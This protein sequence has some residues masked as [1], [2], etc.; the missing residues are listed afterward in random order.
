M[1]PKFE[2]FLVKTGGNANALA[3]LTACSL[4]L[5]LSSLPLSPV[6]AQNVSY[7][8]TVVA[9]SSVEHGEV[10]VPIYLD[11]SQTGFSTPHQFTGLRGIHKLSSV[12]EHGSGHF[13]QGPPILQ[14]NESSV[15]FTIMSE[16]VNWIE[17]GPPETSG[18]SAI[19]EFSYGST[20]FVENFRDAFQP[21]TVARLGVLVNMDP[22]RVADGHMEVYNQTVVLDSSN[23][24]PFYSTDFTIHGVQPAYVQFQIPQGAR[25]GSWAYRLSV[26]DTNLNF[27]EDSTFDVA[28]ISAP[29]ASYPPDQALP[30]ST[31]D[32]A[33]SEYMLFDNPN[34]S[35]VVL[36]VGGGMIGDISG[37]TPI[38]G[39]SEIGRLGTA[40]YR[41]VYDLVKSGFS[42]VTPYGP[43]Q[44]L[45]FPSSL[46]GH[47]R[48]Q[49]FNK[50]YALGHSAGGVV[51]AWAVL[52]NP[53]LF[54]KAVIADAPLTR[55]STGF[56]FTDLSVRSEQ[57][58]VP[59]LLIWG[60]GDTQADVGNAFAWMD[61]ADPSLAVLKIYDYYHDWAGTAAE[62]QVR[63]QIASFFKGQNR[64]A[65]SAST[66]NSGGVGLIGGLQSVGFGGNISRA[67]AG[68]L[69]CSALVGSVAFLFSKRKKK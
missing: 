67:T 25:E 1:E 23:S 5:L 41:L 61:H 55:E 37:P 30:Y 9:H 62:L 54:S 2:D 16:G 48:G 31:F 21:G 29:L 38:N 40:S 35:T 18:S 53:G 11:D 52:N 69:L 8:I 43:W 28:R 39:F 20:P 32:L 3:L 4:L 34:S 68:V 22:A 56:Y 17:V 7:S 46:V 50:F 19:V 44:G 24:Q 51:V 47:L 42:V 26:R 63:H 33:G 36:Y 6:A 13:I 57:V 15:G 66:A 58:K 12:N 10:G 65:A 14:S 45:D 60:R 49:G 27:T 59:Q 64:T